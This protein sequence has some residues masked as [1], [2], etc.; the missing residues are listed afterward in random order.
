ME[1]SEMIPLG[2]CLME[3]TE[4]V[5]LS[6]VDDE[7]YPETRAMLN[8]RNPLKYPGLKDFFA[9][10]SHPFAV[11]FSTNTSSRKRAHLLN[12][13]KASVY[14]CDPATWRGLTLI[15]DIEIVDDPAI[16]H[17]L[18]QSDWTMYYPGGPEDP[19]H[20]ALRFLP[21]TAAY[22]AQLSILR[23]EWNGQ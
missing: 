5:Y 3:E 9:A 16:K 17:A 7:G 15:G 11:Y 8:L 14:Y 20:T 2:S 4:V 10:Q 6:T 22:Y 18:W 19:D 13:F 23:W 1:S 21:R 12:N